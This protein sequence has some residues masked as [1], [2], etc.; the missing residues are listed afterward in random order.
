MTDEELKVNVEIFLTEMANFYEKECVLDVKKDIHEF[1][2]SREFRR[3]DQL[4]VDVFTNYMVEQKIIDPVGK[5]Y[6]TM[7]YS[8]TDNGWSII[9]EKRKFLSGR[10]GN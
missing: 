1:M 8:L 4:E 10:F 5:E 2:V 6:R 7:R 3:H 9:E